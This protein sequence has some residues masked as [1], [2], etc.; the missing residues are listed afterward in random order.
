VAEAEEDI[1]E[2]VDIY[3]NSD[4]LTSR[5]TEALDLILQKN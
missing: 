3:R 1:N 2:I 5:I 4:N